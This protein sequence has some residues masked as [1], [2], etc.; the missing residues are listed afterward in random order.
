MFKTLDAAREAAE[1][2]AENYDAPP[3]I[4]ETRLASGERETVYG[5][6]FLVNEAFNPEW[7]KDEYG[8]FHRM[9]E[10]LQKGG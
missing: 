6:R 1:K 3:V 2:F 10:V 5:F 7:V 8:A 4:I 9:V